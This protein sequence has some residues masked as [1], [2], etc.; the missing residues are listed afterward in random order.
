MT[1]AG[2]AAGIRHAVGQPQIV[3]VR[4]KRSDAVDPDMVV[5][6]GLYD[7]MQDQEH[8]PCIDIHLIFHPDQQHITLDATA[9]RDL[10][11][12]VAEAL[13][14]EHVHRQQHK[15][16]RWRPGKPHTVPASAD[17]AEKQYLGDPDELD[18]YGFSLA[19][20]LAFK[21]SCFE[22]DTDKLASSLVYKSY[23]RHFAQDQSVLL[24]LHS[25]ISK[26]LCRLEVDFYEQNNRPDRRNKPRRVQ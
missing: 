14:H 13:G 2:L 25:H 12:D 4:T 11:F 8:E 7:P 1:P 15:R 24:K 23:V 26:Y 17:L 21:H 9:F 6:G 22:L 18:A 19:A 16:R 3:K 10:C 5:V 20:E